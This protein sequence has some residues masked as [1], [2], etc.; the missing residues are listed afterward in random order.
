MSA[1]DDYENALFGT[2]M[3][4]AFLLWQRTAIEAELVM[5]GNIATNALLVKFPEIPGP[6]SERGYLVTVTIPEATS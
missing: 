1:R 3:L 2:G 4:Q 6:P 5:D